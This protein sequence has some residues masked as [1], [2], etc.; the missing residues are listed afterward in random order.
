VQAINVELDQYLLELG[1]LEFCL[2]V[3]E[4]EAFTLELAICNDEIQRSVVLGRMVKT[5]DIELPFEAGN[6][7]SVRDWLI[8]LP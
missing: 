3:Q 8:A 5:R 7:A 6:L 2:D 1:Q 4:L